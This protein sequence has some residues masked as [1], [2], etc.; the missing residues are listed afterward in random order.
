VSASIG[1]SA[2]K[3]ENCRKL[4]RD[5]TNRHTVDNSSWKEV[6]S[7][8]I[9]CTAS[10]TADTD[11]LNLQLEAVR[12]NGI[13]TME[14]IRSLLV[15]VFKL[16]SEVQQLRIDNDALKTQLRE[17]QQAQLRDLQQAPCHVPS[18]QREAVS[19]AIVKK[20]RQNHIGMLCV[21]WVVTLVPPRSRLQLEIFY[22]RR[23]L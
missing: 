7:A 12:P 18:L 19:S 16:R 11:S 6:L 1:K 4:A 9:E 13:C 8:E 21:Q 3:C 15:M 20:L 2:F 23:P 17:L 14:M 5:T 10:R 22:L